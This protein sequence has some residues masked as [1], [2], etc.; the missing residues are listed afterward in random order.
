M[1]QKLSGAPFELLEKASLKEL[2]KKTTFLL[3]LASAKRVS[4]LN[5]LSCEVRHSEKWTFIFPDSGARL[6][7]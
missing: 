3:A 5:A 7:S 6:R 1:L 2:S 4:E